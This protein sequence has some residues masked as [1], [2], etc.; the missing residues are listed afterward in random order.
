MIEHLR[1]YKNK[2][3]WY[4][5][6]TTPVIYSKPIIRVTLKVKVLEVHN[7]YCVCK[8]IEVLKDSCEDKYYLY[9]SANNYLINCS[10][11]NLFEINGV[12]Y[13]S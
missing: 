3:L 10:N 12:N 7:T 13:E 8:I 4:V 2:E 6:G 11:K 1:K 5:L 9:C